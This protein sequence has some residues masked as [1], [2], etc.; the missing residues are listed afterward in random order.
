M[1]F[2]N[3]LVEALHVLCAYQT[4]TFVGECVEGKLA[5]VA[6]DTTVT[7]STKR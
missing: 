5:V 7:N 6:T 3:V 1:T 2:P 4:G